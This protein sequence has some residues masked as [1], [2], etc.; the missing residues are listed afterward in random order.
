MPTHRSLSSRPWLALCHPRRASGSRPFAWLLAGISVASQAQEAASEPRPTASSSTQVVRHRQLHR[1]VSKMKLQPVAM[2]SIDERADVA[3]VIGATNARPSCCARVPGICAR[4]RPVASESNANITVRGV[5]LSAGG[6][7]Y[8][9]MQEDGLPVLLF[10]D[11]AFGTAD[12]SS[13]ARTTASI[14]WKWCAAARPRCWP[15]ARRAAS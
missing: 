2:S 14:A 4:S 1:Q 10:G 5:P 9:Q 13:C 11:I 6:S 8:V 15:P 7:R 3:G 12:T